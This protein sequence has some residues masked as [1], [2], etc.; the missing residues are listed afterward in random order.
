[1]I[2][3]S[4]LFHEGTN[5]RRDHS[6]LRAVVIFAYVDIATGPLK[7]SSVGVQTSASI[8]SYVRSI[9]SSSTFIGAVELNI[10]CQEDYWRFTMDNVA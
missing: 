6:Y 10:S 3:P 8:K 7:Y 1:M 2:D 9:M 4:R 5:D